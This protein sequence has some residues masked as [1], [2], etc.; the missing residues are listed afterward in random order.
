LLKQASWHADPVKL[1]HFRTPKGAEVDIVLERNG[2]V[3]G[4][5][6]R[7]GQTVT[8]EDFRGLKVLAELAKG[9]FHRGLVLYFGREAVAFGPNL[10]AVPLTALWEW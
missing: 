4:V 3:V 9:R 1:F 2:D 8:A 7:S 6:V 10:Q 5:E